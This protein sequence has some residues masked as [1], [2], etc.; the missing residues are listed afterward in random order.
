MKIRAAVMP[1]LCAAALLITGLSLLAQKKH[2]NTVIDL[3]MQGKAAFGVFVPNEIAPPPRTG[4]PNA[5]GA[6]AAGAAAGAQRQA[7][8]RPK[9]VYTR[10]GGERL[11]MNPLYDYV[12][13]NMEGSYDA[14]Q[15]KAIAEGLRSPKAVGRK[16]LIVRVPAFHEDDGA[17][18]ARLRE[19]FAL[20][21]DGITF[22]HVESVDEGRRILTAAAAEKLDVWSP[23]NPGGEKLLMMMIEDPKA[24]EQ[25]REFADLKGYSILACGIGSLTSALGGNREQAEAGNQKILAETKRTRLVN[26]LTA[27]PDDVEKRVKEGFLALLMQGPR[28]DEAIKIGRAAAGR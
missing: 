20:G 3:W 28:A 18:R 27:S 14:A 24:L 19:V 23:V 11:A 26:M 13:L 8:A 5:P 6:P 2:T 16:A 25:A 17:G 21:A 22:P 4:A 1:L 7:G 10:E 12:F 15:I 9:P